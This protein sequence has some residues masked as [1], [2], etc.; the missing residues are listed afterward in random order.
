LP[1]SGGIPTGEGN[2]TVAVSQNTQNGMYANHASKSFFVKTVG[3][4]E[5]L[6]GELRASGE[7]RKV[8]HARWNNGSRARPIWEYKVMAWGK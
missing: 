2:T 6:K 1:Y 5:Q 8:S 3:E 7:Y 4:M